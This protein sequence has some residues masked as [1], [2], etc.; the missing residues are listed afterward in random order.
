MEKPMSFDDIMNYHPDNKNVF[1]SI[2]QNI[3][4]L[5]PFVG[6]GLSAFCYPQWKGALTKIAEPITNPAHKEEVEA[7]IKTDLIQAAQQIENYLGKRRLCQKLLTIFTEDKIAAYDA[8]LNQQN[9]S[10]LPYLFPEKPAVTTNFDRVLETVYE[11]AGFPFDAKILPG[12][13]ELHN[14]L[15]QGDKHGLFK[16]HGD[17]GR[18]T[19]EYSSIIFTEQQYND[20]YQ[21]NSTLVQELKRWFQNRSLFFLGCSLKQDKTMDLLNKIVALEPGLTHFAII[22]CAENDRDERLKN[23][24][25]HYGIFA[26]AYPPKK[27]EAVRIILEKLLEGTDNKA[28]Q[29]LPYHITALKDEPDIPVNPFVYNA[30]FIPFTGR[31]EELYQLKAFCETEGKVKWWAVTGAGGAGKSRLVY[32]FTEQMKQQGWSVKY[33]ETADYAD[34][35]QFDILPQKTIVVADYVQAYLT[36]IGHWLEHLKHISRSTPI[37][38]LLI[39]RDG[40]NCDDSSWGELFVNSLKN[41]KF[42]QDNCYQSELL[43]L[44]PMEELELQQIME[45]YAEQSGRKLTQEQSGQLFQILQTVDE[46][47]CRPLYALFIADAWVHDNNPIHWDKNRI[48]EYVIQKENSYYHKKADQLAGEHNKRLCNTLDDIRAVATIHGD[49]TITELSECYPNIWAD[50]QKQTEYIPS[51]ES[52]Q[53]FLKQVG[54]LQDASTISAMRPDLMGEYY[55][56]KQIIQPNKLDLLFLDQWDENP[57]MIIFLFRMISDYHDDLE[58]IPDFWDRLFR[59][60]S[61]NPTIVELFSGLLVNIANFFENYAEAAVT[62]LETY[63]K[64]NKKN[65][66]L[67]LVYAIGLFNLSNEQNLIERKNSVRKLKELSLSYPDNSEF[68]VIY[69]K[70]LFNLS[71]K[72]DLAGAEDSTQQLEQLVLSYPDSSEIALAYAKGLFNLSYEQDLAGAKVSIQK[73]EQLSNDYPDISEIVVV[74]AKGLVNLSVEQNLV[75]AEDSIR[76]L[77]ELSNDY[78]EI[79]L[80]YAGGLVNLSNRQN[81]AGA[82]DSIRKLKELSNDYPDN[83][84]IALVYAK[85]LVNLSVEQNLA[86]RKD[87]IQKLEQLFNRYSGNPEIALEYAKG[88][89]HLSLKQDLAGRK[90]SIRK[91][92]KLSNDYLGNSKIILVYAYGL[93]NL[94]D[95]Q[96]LAGAETSLRKLE[97]LFNTDPANPEIIAVYAAGLFN[98]SEKQ[99]KTQAKQ[100]LRKAEKLLD[101]HPTAAKILEEDFHVTIEELLSKLS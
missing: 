62:L 30:D 81:L 43:E 1:E 70:G 33:L 72:Q 29:K 82:E 78:P 13:P 73:L 88:L 14:Q 53:D 6:A 54:Y 67:A 17:I 79:A 97:Q 51:V 36:E 10:V 46:G 28:Y 95:E 91:L 39:E 16:V 80:Q 94:S 61:S 45:D 23:L 77:K 44:Q 60:D 87:S 93:V 47:L 5:T 64:K 18:D 48:L 35:T 38:I 34:L 9:V 42:V 11:A 86:G 84:E 65:I 76:K 4:N 21:K 98:L 24:A 92:E 41:R 22:D 7:T 56:L 96:D 12:R 83:P 100:T 15:L 8:V 50:L 19:I 37:R 49:I 69:A 71:L 85:G 90:E 3:S 59:F 57:Q 68:A 99:E 89:F 63:Q 52:E 27:H 101:E 26:I 25:D 74:Y 66:R 55:V 32:E 20:A 40:Q 58:N 2:K 75:G 31:T